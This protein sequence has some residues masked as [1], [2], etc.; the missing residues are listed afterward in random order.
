LHS[1][2]TLHDN[3][4]ITQTIARTEGERET[5]RR[6]DRYRQPRRRCSRGRSTQSRKIK[7]ARHSWHFYAASHISLPTAANFFCFIN[8]EQI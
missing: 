1:S 8:L 3:L 7:I 2:F 5:K 6:A 4:I